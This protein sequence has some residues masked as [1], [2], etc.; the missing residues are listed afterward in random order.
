MKH[1]L[2]L[3]ALLSGMLFVAACGATTP[4]PTSPPPP[5][6]TEAKPAG[7]AI[8]VVMKDIYY[9]EENTNAD[10]PPTWE[11]SAGSE[12]ALSLD[13]QG[14]LEHDWAIVKAGETV[15]TPF[16]LAESKEILL[17]E[18]GAVAAGSTH[19]ATFTAPAEPGEYV[20]ICTVAGH[21]P[22]MQGRLV[23]E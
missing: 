5:P 4:A 13:N 15:P 23:V 17:F 8:T 19:E 20:V 1:I 9:G 10:H 3:I 7:A 6:P 12:V 11:V 21:Y 2:T 22:L 14:A 16:M 18:A